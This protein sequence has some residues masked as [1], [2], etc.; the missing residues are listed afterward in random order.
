MEKIK[1]DIQELNLTL[2]SRLPEAVDKALRTEVAC[3]Q[4]TLEAAEKD[5]SSIR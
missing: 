5:F 3:K 2:R 1:K 4:K